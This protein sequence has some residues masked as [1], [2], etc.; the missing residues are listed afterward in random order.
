MS[1]RATRKVVSNHPER[2]EDHD[3]EMSW[4]REILFGELARDVDRRFADIGQSLVVTQ[5][6]IRTE[7]REEM[8]RIADTTDRLLL[9]KRELMQHMDEFEE[10]MSNA[11][12]EF[13]RTLG[14]SSA[15]LTQTK[16]EQNT[17]AK[18]FEQMAVQ[19]RDPDDAT[20]S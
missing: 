15:R 14:D 1:D 13:T 17:L 20:A 9:L 2:T 7:F 3:D 5:Q 6:A 8:T 11:Q 12:D 16:V 19:L 18:L 4:I 10:R